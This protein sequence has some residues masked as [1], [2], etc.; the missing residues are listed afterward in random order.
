MNSV[1]LRL[2]AILAHPD[3][4]SLGVGGALAR[5]AS[6]GVEVSLVTATRGENGRYLQHREGPE[7]PGRE[8]LGAIREAE[9]RA[10]AA[11]LGVKDLTLLGYED[12]R[13]DRADPC[14][15]IGR[16]VQ[17]VRRVRPHVVITFPP[18]GSYGHPDH[19]ASSQLAT[20]AMVAAADPAHRSAGASA[21]H[22]VSKL[23][24]FVANQAEW[25]VYQAVFK[26]LVSTVDGIE[27]QATA[28][29]EWSI[30]TVV[31]TREHW[32]V[33][34]KAVSAHVS[35]IANYR[36]L[37]DLPPERHAALWGARRFYRAYSTVN[38]GPRRETDLFEGL[39][40]DP[41]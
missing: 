18:D 32:P 15:A 31:D 34:W 6:E 16:I 40:G 10:A 17:H 12:G 36:G 7:H 19:I 20:A 38:G 30:T 35:Q 28:W 37:Q 2:M 11:A 5:Y 13:L 24:Y 33:V 4:E 9:L 22:A 29:P 23:Y 21:P 27:R 41:S 26:K 25:E 14:E 8:R 3:D 39:R 1:T